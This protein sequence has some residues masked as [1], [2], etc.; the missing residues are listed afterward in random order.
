MGPEPVHQIVGSGVDILAYGPGI[1]L[2][3]VVAIPT[4]EQPPPADPI[5]VTDI[6]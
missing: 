3:V 4:G 1:T 2:I 6:V 5:A